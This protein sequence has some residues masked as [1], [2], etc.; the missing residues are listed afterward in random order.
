[1]RRLNIKIDGK[2]IE[3]VA[4]KIAGQVWFHYQGETYQY[5]PSADGDATGAGTAAQDPTRIV[6]P[7][8][9]KIIKVFSSEG[10]KVKEG[11][12]VVAM[13]AMK[14]EY[15]LKAQQ[16]MVVKKVR[17][18]AGDQVTLG[19]VLVELEEENG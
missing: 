9:G 2:D 3:V 16:D 18:Q 15:N 8:P 1:M 10:Q 7:M 19:G 17:C 12:T 6:A 14:M 13:E 5:K 4:Q 11:E